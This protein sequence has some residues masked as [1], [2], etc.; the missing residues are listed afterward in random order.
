MPL[1][2]SA[3]LKSMR[4]LFDIGHLWLFCPQKAEYECFIYKS[5]HFLV[6]LVSM[7]GVVK[8]TLNSYN[9]SIAWLQSNQLFFSVGNVN[10]LHLT[11]R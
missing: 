8:E 11:E 4:K 7:S 5:Q 2:T 3:S 9:L 10:F 1:L 6:R